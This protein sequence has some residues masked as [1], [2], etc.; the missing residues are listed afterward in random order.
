MEN[1]IPNK[2]VIVSGANGYFGGIACQ[3]FESKGWRVLQATRQPGADIFIDLDRPDELIH[4]SVDFNVNLFIHAAAAHEVT[5]REQPYRSIIQNVV[6]TK[7]ALDFCIANKIPNF[8]YLS[9]FHVFG[10]PSGFIDETNQPLP[11]NDYGLS[12]LQAEEYV[13]MYTRQHKLRGL[14]IRPSN[15]FGTPANLKT[16]KRWTL[17][18]LA[19]CKEAIEHRQIVL[20]TPGFQR[21]NFVSVLDI[22]AA[23]DSAI[24]RIEEIPLLHIA[25][26]DTLSIRELAQLVQKVAHNYLNIKVELTIPDGTPTEDSFV[27]TSRYLSNV[28]QPL[29]RLEPFIVDFCQ[30][31]QSEL[32]TIY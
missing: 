5:C 8:V 19:F 30:K 25:G 7:A 32:E 22:C 12:H 6:G 3:Y 17:T 23:I 16:C 31:I 2:T 14:V 1:S 27:Y 11:A 20:R 18:P 4:Q 26:P 21:R 28:H 10:H 13:Q 15:F 29:Y 9:T 24:A